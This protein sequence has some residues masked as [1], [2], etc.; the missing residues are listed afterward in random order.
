MDAK[1]IA[2]AIISGSFDN[3]ELNIIV[4]AIKFSRARMGERTKRELA[5]GNK[6]KFTDPR[7][8][9]EHTGTITKIKIKNVLVNCPTFG[10]GG[11]VNVP[12][13]LLSLA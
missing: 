4:D 6:V 10:R 3:D 11:L 7:T 12:A 8:G 2:S 9:V 5:I 1:Q 13:N